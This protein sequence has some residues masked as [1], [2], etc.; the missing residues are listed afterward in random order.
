M[1]RRPLLIG[2]AAAV[3]AAGLGVAGI[4]AAGDEAAPPGATAAAAPAGRTY[5]VT[6][7]T[8][9]VVTATTVASG[10]ARVTVEPADPDGVYRRTC[11]PDGHV[12]VV[13]AAVAPLVGRQLDEDLFD[14]TTLIEEGYDDARSADVPVIVKAPASAAPLRSGLR[15][16]RRLASIGAVA[17]RYPKP[18]RGTKSAAGFAAAAAGDRVWLD[19]RVRMSG[20]A[21][22]PRLDG[23]LSQVDAP[24]AW[25]AGY[26]GKGVRVAVLDTGVDA[27]HP[28]LAGK[29]V[30][31]ADFTAADGTAVDRH[32][33]GTHVAATAVGSGAGAGGRRRGV[34]PDARLVVGK[35]LHDDGSGRASDVIAGM[36][37]AAPRAD[38]VNLSLGSANSDGTDPVSQAVETLTERHG[39]LFVAA[40]GNAGPSESTVGAPA[41][42]PAA[43]AVGAVDA[44]DRLA[45]FS[46][47]GPVLGSRAAKPEI[48]APGVDIVAARAAGTTLG[49]PVDAR[50]TT[51][52]GTSMAT[53]HV[54]GA[55][56]N[57]LQ[58]H[59]EWT[60]ARLK[61]AL[62]G[63][64]EP[65]TGGD[66]YEVG[67]GRL[68]AAGPLANVVAGQA[69]VNLGTLS[70]PQSG[71]A[72]ITLA[73][74]NTGNAAL[75][76]ALDVT[77]GDRYG[78]SSPD[79]A[80]TLDAT[81][82]SI[83][84]GGLAS[85]RLRLDRSRLGARPG[86]YVATVTTR[87]G[88]TSVRTPVAFFVEPPSHDLTVTL[89]APADADGADLSGYVLVANLDD[90]A[91]FYDDVRLVGADGTAT[92]R[93]PAGR[94]S[95]LGDV[96]AQ[97]PDGELRR[98]VLAGTPDVGV[99]AD[100]AVVLDGAA[101]KPVTATVAGDETAHTQIVAAF[102]QQ[103][104]R[105]ELW[106][107]NLL[108]FGTA[109]AEGRISAT[110]TGTASVGT[111]RPYQAFVLD[112]TVDAT[113]YDL[114]RE[115]PGRIPDDPAY[116]VAAADRELARIDQRFPTPG[117]PGASTAHRR[118]GETPDGL[119]L[120]EEEWN[121]RLPATRTDYVSPGI[122]WT[123]VGVVHGVL[124]DGIG[125]IEPARTYAAGSRQEKIWGRG[126]LRPDWYDDP[127]ASWSPCRPAPV[128]RARGNLR[129]Q[130]V[131]L[132]DQHQRFTCIG[133]LEEPDWVAGT[134]RKLALYRDGKLLGEHAGSAADFPIPAQ[135]GTYRLTYELDASRIL[136]MS[137]RVST[138]WTFRS[139]PPSGNGAAPVPVLS[140]DYALP[141]GVFTVRQARDTA[142]QR[143]TGFRV[144][145]S[146]DDGA[147]WTEH[148]ARRTAGDRF[149]APL[150][151][152]AGTPVSLRVAA[153]ADGGSGSGFEQT[154][155]RAY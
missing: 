40:A 121:D 120:I 16:S 118:L 128:S 68:D 135:G 45:D 37:W 30:E 79:G 7:I 101:G 141:D 74:H 24:G 36:E 54:A 96:Y 63:A 145:T 77:V 35:V 154:I 108:G 86:L 4:S 136:P 56:A 105:G 51:A 18:G 142:A 83:P 71:T 60:A 73:W 10:C 92:F 67:A 139:T 46:S 43:L 147:T 148:P 81:T 8:G 17:G 66:G 85:T 117:A 140:V 155:L 55:A 70:H 64:A 15:E 12:R 50:Y 122:G 41:A 143:I 58:R 98:A 102:T 49:R 23:N 100:T 116:R 33:H 126:P 84:A 21:A 25:A 6:L 1:R 91:L 88:D 104:R 129:V 152:A 38:V 153:T 31:K 19:R 127:A 48:V 34:A 132:T 53:P 107:Y 3:V 134:D 11:G 82:L 42:A 146:T 90:P 138:A 115:L 72:E 125:L 13:P 80:V 94:Y 62:V 114:I 75:D 123:D 22:A 87:S 2:L 32:G 110:P 69:L 20:L 137:T 95:V 39:T 9:D 65:A 57:L 29:V 103:P 26:T 47:R 111:F 78:N 144:W 113:H 59:P 93:V 61:A 109:A 5:R 52:S 151:A 106:A 130:L 97:A 44:Q 76:V 28:D 124:P 89:A 14:I 149:A 112:S 27:S 131:D 119:L 150:P 133:Y 99:T